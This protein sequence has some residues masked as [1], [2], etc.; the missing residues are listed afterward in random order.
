[1][2]NGRITFSRKIVVLIAVLALLAVPLVALADEVVVDGDTVASGNQSIIDLGT[3]AP[4]AKLNPQV[5]FTLVCSSK[6]HVDQ[7]QILTLAFSL[8]GSTVPADG[9][10][11]A[12][13]ASIG[14][15]PAD[16]PDD[17]T[18]SGSTNCGSPAPSPI[19]DN[20][21]SLVTITAPTTPS[22][23]QFV[24]RYTFGAGSLSPAGNNDNS[25][26][27]GN[28]VDVIYNLTV[29]GPSDITPPIITIATDTGDTIAE[30]GWYNIASSGT[31]GVKV[32]VSA[33][34]PSNISN[35]TCIDNG[36][37][38]VL[39]VS[40][41]SGSFTLGNGTHSISC[42]ATDGANNTGAGGGS[43]TMPVI[44][45]IDQTAPSISAALDKSPD[46]VTGWF[47]IATGAP[48]VSFTCS[49]T[50]SGLAGTCPASHTFGEGANQNYS[51]SVSDVAGNSASAGVTGINVD[52]TAPTI[53]ASINPA[54]PASTGW[55]N[56]S[57]GAPTVSFTCSDTGG[58]GIASCTAPVTLSDGA[59]QTVNG[60]ATDVAGNSATASKTSINVDL[61]APTI[62]A[63]ISPASPA[64]T[65]WYNIS[66]GAPT[67]SFT[68]NDT[69]GSGLASV[70]PA[71]VPLGNGAGQSVS[72]GPISDVA[73]N[74]SGVATI[75]N[76]NVDLIAPT[77]SASISPADPASTGWYNISTGAPTVSYVCADIGSSGLASGACHA[78]VPLGEGANQSVPA[79]TVTDIAGNTSTPSASFSGINVDLTAP[80]G[81][82]GAPNRAPDH[83]G[84][85]NHAVD[86]VFTGSDATSGID[87]CTTVNYSTPDGSG[88]TVNGTC[89]DNAGNTSA[90]VASSAF[91][92]DATAPTLAPTVSPN[93]VILNG[94]AT[95]TPNASDATSG[96][97]T[98]SCD[99]VDTS[100]VGSHSVNCTAT[101]KAG[102]TATGSASYTVNF[103]L[104]VLYDQTKSHKAGS[105][106]PLKLQLCDANGVN[107][108]S[109][110]IVVKAISVSKIDNSASGVLDDSGSANSP[111]MNFR[112]DATLGTTGGYI[113]NLST[114]GLTTG[115]WKVT[116]T[117][118]GV[119]TSSYFVQFDIK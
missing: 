49:D 109:A 103:G 108:S 15:I 62:V 92:Y 3:V 28:H 98:S 39:N 68:C 95:A 93:P 107:Y 78:A 117:V 50:G 45:R 83:N 118:D 96:V 88:V 52:L 73:G 58:S 16:W 4:G 76:I 91:D 41:N 61:T 113:F 101:D 105:T 111:D 69:G 97:A 112:Y 55:Y 8:S 11:S 31:D 80:T 22:S 40:V 66:T 6:Q 82:S 1:M 106:V 26:V 48:T 114:K 44:Y 72:G 77:I 74:S 116:F 33:S 27:Q 38:T 67:V 24:V 71:S 81:V 19:N 18:S 34:D 35:I 100:S 47:N 53:V 20:G 102:N 75:S 29:A 99:P 37:T 85:Y 65:G 104:C 115:S 59:N 119:G 70:C 64:S 23:Y 43:T 110:S 21:N 84:W 54:S 9:S 94:S 13:D 86:V 56:I 32:N 42:T 10:L 30:T 36:T 89:T 60:T 14:A 79:Q 5:S 51:A 87:S 12:T 90:P 7:G 57:T 46:A 25:A 17:T 2:T 63:S